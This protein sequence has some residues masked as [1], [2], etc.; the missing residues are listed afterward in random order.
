[1]SI[2]ES[3]LFAV[4]ER[5]GD[6]NPRIGTPPDPLV[7]FPAKHPAVGDVRVTDVSVAPSMAVTVLVGA[8]MA[9]TFHTFRR[10][11]RTCRTCPAADERGCAA[12]AGTLR[13]SPV[14][15]AIDRRPESGMARA[16]R[17]GPH[18]AARQRQSHVRE[19]LVVWPAARVAGRSQRSP[20]AAGFGT[21]ASIN[22][23]PGS[24]TAWGLA[25]SNRPS[26]SCSRDWLP[27]YTGAEE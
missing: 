8:V 9:D 26:V 3:L 6:R 10:S 15:M 12:P 16:R 2:R 11:P 14:D 13:R 7:V 18:R 1:M 21:T 17:C 23:W 5:F 20:R 4:M 27:E 25:I 22:S 19:I 24:S